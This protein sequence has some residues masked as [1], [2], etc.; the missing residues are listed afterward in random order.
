VRPEDAVV[1]PNERFI[2]GGTGT[3]ILAEYGASIGGN[4]TEIQ[5]MY[6][7][8]DLYSNLGYEPLSDSDIIKQYQSGGLV[9][10]DKGGFSDFMSGGG[11]QAISSLMGA[12]FSQLGGG[13]AAGS[14]IGGA[15]GQGLSMIPGVGPLL[16]P[17]LQALGAGIGAIADAKG[18]I[19]AHEAAVTAMNARKESMN[20]AKEK[21]EVGMMNSFDFNQAQS[22]YTNAQSEVVRTKYDA[23]FKIKVVEFYFGI[24]ISEM[25]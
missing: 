10:K 1:S 15:L 19:N 9:S 17:G 13:A 25:K 5:N 8:G 7:P 11:G 6:N 18:A 4:P 23:I 24:P 3:E 2:P 21:Y 12:G 16:A 22:L 20:Y 14:Q